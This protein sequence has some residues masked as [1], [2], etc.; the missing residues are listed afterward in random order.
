MHAW[1]QAGVT[2]E[3][4]RAMIDKVDANKSGTLGFDEFVMVMTNGEIDIVAIAAKAKEDEALLT[5]EVR[6]TG[7]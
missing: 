7:K 3:S 1:R 2:E 6:T 4:A 5:I